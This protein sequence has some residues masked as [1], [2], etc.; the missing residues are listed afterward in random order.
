MRSTLLHDIDQHRHP[1][2]T[3]S[4]MRPIS[5]AL[6][7]YMQV[8]IVAKIKQ[9]SQISSDPQSTEPSGTKDLA[10][11]EPAAASSPFRIQVC[12]GYDTHDASLLQDAIR[13]GRYLFWDKKADF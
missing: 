6:K 13:S 3:H 8:H 4:M 5:P 1:F 11:S 12:L 9:Q 10:K 7:S 2:K